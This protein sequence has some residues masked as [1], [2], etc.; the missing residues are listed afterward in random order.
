MQHHRVAPL[1]SHLSRIDVA[2]EV[3]RLLEGLA[4][5]KLQLLNRSH[6]PHP[7]LS[8]RFRRVVAY[9]D[10]VDKQIRKGGV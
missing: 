3:Q 10:K 1:A 7:E 5:F 9:G 8:T 4:H 2:D 6:I